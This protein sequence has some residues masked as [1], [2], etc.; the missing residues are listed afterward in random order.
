MRHLRQVAVAACVVLGCSSSNAPRDY[1]VVDNCTPG[2]SP[3]AICS[4]AVSLAGLPAT[5]L[6]GI[7]WIGRGL[8]PTPDLN[9]YVFQQSTTFTTDYKEVVQFTENVLGAIAKQSSANPV[10][11]DASGKYFY[12]TT[13]DGTWVVAR[14]AH[15]LRWYSVPYPQV[16][17]PE[18]LK[19]LAVGAGL[20]PAPV[21]AQIWKKVGRF[22]VDHP[23]AQP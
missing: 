12:W 3:N 20:R 17:T 18:D 10:A 9:G 2:I 19:D 4:V 6:G 14:D 8:K 13:R 15:E 23:A 11:L 7:I 16:R 5:H 22:I 21:S 1:S